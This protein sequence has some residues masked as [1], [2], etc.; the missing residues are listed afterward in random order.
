MTVEA[1]SK[2]LAVTSADP[3]AIQLQPISDSI[4]NP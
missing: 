1:R 3:T 2:T 4:T